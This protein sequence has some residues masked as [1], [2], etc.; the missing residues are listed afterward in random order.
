M[1]RLAQAYVCLTEPA[2]KRAY[3]AA[4]LG[5]AAVALVEP[6]PAADDPLESHDPLA[7]LY[8]GDALN[9]TAVIAAPPAPPTLPALPQ[10]TPA[11]DAAATPPQPAPEPIDPVIEA[12]RSAPAQRGLATKRA[13]YYRIARTRQLLDAWNRLGKYVANPKRRLARQVEADELVALLE[14]VELL[15]QGFPRLMGEAGQPGYLVITL[16][17]LDQPIKSFQTLSPS[18]R[19]AL[20]RDWQSGHKLLKEH[21]DFLREEVRAMRRR[22]LGDR[23]VRATRSFLNDHPGGLLVLLGLLALSIAILHQALAPN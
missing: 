2:S 12:A 14:E 1:N 13:L 6:E 15:L 20:E 4:L 5:V 7:W 10:P 17:Q 9:G 23:L 3:D 21:C 19:E 16:A 22:S 11:P 18:Q 8:S